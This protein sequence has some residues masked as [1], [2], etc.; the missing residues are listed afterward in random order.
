MPVTDISQ[1]DLDGS[2]SYADYLTWRLSERLELI[3]GKIY[4]ISPASNTAH[5]RIS[6]SLGLILGNFL[7]KS[8]CQVFT[9]PF[10][11]RLVKKKK[12][13]KSI[14]TVVQPDI[15]VICDSEKIDERGCLGSP[16]LIVEILSPGNSRKEMRDKFVLYE[17]NGVKE[18]WV[19]YPSEEVLQIFVLSD[20]KYTANL[21][22]VPGDMA[23]STL[24]HDLSVDVAEIFDTK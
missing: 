18:Y 10:D 5:Q 13:D 24:W 9:A 20:G 4:R 19:I 3:K 12:D 23:R 11:V 21:P 16:D 2:Y 15:C 1:L 22:L 14:I 6:F 7:K 8:Q 17:E